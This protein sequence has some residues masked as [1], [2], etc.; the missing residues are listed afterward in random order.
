MPEYSTMGGLGVR[1]MAEV[2]IC[3]PVHET[4]FRVTGRVY[5]RGRQARLVSA[6]PDGRSDSDP[7]A[8]RT[9]AGSESN[10]GSDGESEPTRTAV[11]P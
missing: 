5:R 3:V 8:P 2:T 7:P 1:E 10:V 9:P 4:G 11:P 6:V